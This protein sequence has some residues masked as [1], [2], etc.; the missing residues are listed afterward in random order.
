MRTAVPAV[1]PTALP[2]PTG[3]SA[4]R[5]RILATADRLFYDEGIHGVGIHRIV[6]EAGVTRVTLYRHFPS[7]DHLIA[8]YLERRG[9]YDRDQIDGL[10]AA[11]PHD[12][13]LALTELATVLTRDDF[14]VTRRGCPFINASAEFTG[15]HTTRVQATAIR[16]WVTGRLE[17]LLTG[18]GHTHA[19]R[20]GVAADDGA[21][22]RRRVRRA[23]PGRRPHR[24]LPSVLEPAHR[25]R[26]DRR[27]N[28]GGMTMQTARRWVATGP[29]GL[30]VL[31][32]VETDVPPPGPGEVT[33]EVRAA[34]MNPADHK[35]FNRG[36][37]DWPVPIGYE[38]SGVLS[39][40]GP[41]T[42]LASGGGTVG[43][44]VLAFRIR[45]G[46]AT[47]LTVPARDV[48]TRPAALDHPAAANL[49]LAGAT[50]AEMLHVT[51]VAAGETIVVHGASGAVGV[52]VLQQARLMG[53]RVIGTASERNFGTVTRFGGVPV[54]YGDGLEARLRDL[55][56]EGYAAALDTVGTDEAVDVSVALVASR[57]RIVTIAAMGRAAETG[58]KL[59]GGTMPASVPFRNAVRP[60]LIELAARGELVV[61]VAR[62]FPL[63]EA[64]AALEH[65]RG[66]HPGGK[67]ALIP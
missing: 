40:V 32:F 62:T 19:P 55:A 56:P 21:H 20:D 12:P 31:A 42:E 49:L 24:A 48:F 7:K 41:D 39:A 50:A 36:D 65:L 28:T 57:A 61:P 14:A 46:Y 4:A 44:D 29:G 53:V 34:G 13:R 3:T 45:G 17:D 25:R 66:G 27:D 18:L 60:R 6:E 5:E 51:E 26:A 11:H 1:H 8:A 67:L 16:A 64:R 59:I 23:R 54:T 2:L 15:D 22:R 38:V 33:I 47:A 63:A 58:I 35:H 10:I 30:E 52:S 43:Q 37:Q 9:Q